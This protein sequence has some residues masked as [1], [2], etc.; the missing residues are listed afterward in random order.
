MLVAMVRRSQP[1]G[2]AVDA[3]RRICT[4]VGNHGK[5]FGWKERHILRKGI[6]MLYVYSRKS[7]AQCNADVL[8][9]AMT[10]YCVTLFNVSVK[11]RL[12]ELQ[13]V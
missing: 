7:A 2:A 5:A 10:I 8:A 9:P 1:A 3:R 12:A 11:R 13:E 4:V 6:G